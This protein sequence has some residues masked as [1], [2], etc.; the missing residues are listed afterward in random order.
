M[1]TGF[2][3]EE[4]VDLL[5]SMGYGGT[6]PNAGRRVGKTADGGIDGVINEGP[7]GLDIVYLQ[8]ER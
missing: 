6:R 7:L 1:R 2:P 5:T 8:A 3:L 4:V